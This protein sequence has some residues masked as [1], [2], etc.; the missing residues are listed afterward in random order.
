[1]LI[2][3]LWEGRRKKKKKREKKFIC[4]FHWP[5]CNQPLHLRMSQN[6]DWDCIKVDGNL[7]ATKR[8]VQWYA[9]CKMAKIMRT[10]KKFANNITTVN[11]VNEE[12]SKVKLQQKEISFKA[13]NKIQEEKE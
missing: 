6:N 12:Q 9:Q 4:Y 13:V 10:T 7:L 5:T 8:A 3:T 1:M 11:G 2:L